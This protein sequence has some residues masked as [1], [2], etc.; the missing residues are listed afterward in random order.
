MY[1]GH[2]LMRRTPDDCE[3]RKT[4]K[5]GEDEGGCRRV[6]AVILVV[7]KI[8]GASKTANHEVH[9]PLAAH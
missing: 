5:M 6:G 9:L 1:R 3:E 7:G 4:L 2:V 8:S